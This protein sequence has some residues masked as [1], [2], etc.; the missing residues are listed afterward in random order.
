MAASKRP[1]GLDLYGCLWPTDDPIKVELECIRLGGTWTTHDGR[2]HGH[3]LPF[4]V[5]QFSRHIWPWFKWHRW[6]HDLHLPELC[7]PRHRLACFG[8]SSSS[9]SSTT[10]LAYLVFYFARPDNTTVLVSSTTREE[11]ELR[12]WGEMKLFFRE[13]KEVAPWLPGHLIDSR[14]MILTDG[15][16]SDARDVRNGVI[17]RPAKSGNKWLVGSGAS[18]FVGIKN[19]YVYLAADEAGLMCAGF[20]EALANLTSNPSCCASI[21]G[22]LGD[23]DTPL[24]QA[25]EPELGWDSLPDSDRSRVYNTRWCNGRALQF[26]GMD[27]PNMDFPEGAEPYPKIIGRRYIEQ[28]ARDYGRDTPFFNMFASGKIPRGT[29]ENRII[30]KADCVRHQAFEP[31]TWGHEKVTRFYPMDVSYTAGHGDR[32]VGRPMAFGRDNQQQW[33]L[34][35]LDRPLVYTPTDRSDLSIEDQIA[36]QCAGECKKWDIPASAVFFDGTGRSSFTAALMRYMGTDVNPIEFGGTATNRPNFLNRRYDEDLDRQR[37][38]GDLLPCDEVFDRMVTELWFAIRALV[39]AKQ[40]RQLDEETVKELE[41]RLWKLTAGNR[42]SVERKEDMKLRL[43]RSP[44]LG[45]LFAVAIE[46]ARR[47]GFPLGQLATPAKP[48]SNWLSKLDKDYREA[49]A[50]VEL[51]VA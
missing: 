19:D 14:Q 7:R 23:L 18:P 34:A 38:K 41:K 1:R 44:D 5:I 4:H 11:L 43:G 40:C 35:C 47:L 10:A 17:G 28:C 2:S 31:V 16:D 15:K 45:D 8:P 12:I 39:E 9:K 25:A 30:T 24:G 48:R 36:L 32:T 27:S 33:R 29:M 3:G 26:V 21:L 46:G 37:K 50:A 20:L 22:N 51:T 6:A 13:A 49:Q 42:I